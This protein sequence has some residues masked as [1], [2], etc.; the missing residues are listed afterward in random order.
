MHRLTVIALLYPCLT[1]FVLLSAKKAILPATVDQPEV[2]FYWD[3]ASLPPEIQKKEEYRGGIYR[4]FDDAVMMR[5][6][7]IDAVDTWNSVPGAFVRLV[8]R[9]ADATRPV[10]EDR[11]DRQNSMIVLEPENLTSAAYAQPEIQDETST[12]IDCD[13]T[14]AK[15]ATAAKELAYTLIHE[16]GHCLG[17]GHAHT[18]YNAIMGYSR[19]RRDLALG[20]DDIAGI[21]YLYPD[22]KYGDERPKELASCGVTAQAQAPATSKR[23]SLCLLLLPVLAVGFQNGRRLARAAQT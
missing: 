17:L 21:I 16:L 22:P 13:I 19:S 5:Q 7:L 1:G 20:A 10:R 2:V 8:L 6:L 4:S 14:I 23:F 9:E 3:P 18:N 11:Q 15:K 12:I